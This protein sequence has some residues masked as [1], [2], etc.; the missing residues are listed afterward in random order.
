L[1]GRSFGQFMAPSALNV[2]ASTVACVFMRVPMIAARFATWALH[3][4]APG[5]TIP[6]HLRR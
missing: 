1:P 3:D 4:P 6:P 5:G 2:S